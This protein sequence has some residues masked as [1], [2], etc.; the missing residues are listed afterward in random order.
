MQTAKLITHLS[1]IAGACWSLAGELVR[2]H[3]DKSPE[4]NQ[5]RTK[6]WRAIVSS[7]VELDRELT[8]ETR[9]REATK[10]VAERN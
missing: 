1:E 10:N 2:T 8:A 9:T 4:A 7:V 3:D 5:R 6:Q